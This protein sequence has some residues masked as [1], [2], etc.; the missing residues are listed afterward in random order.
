MS[1]M[2][3]ACQLQVS[4]RKVTEAVTHD[5]STL[6]QSFSSDRPVALRRGDPSS[7]GPV[8]RVTQRRIN[9]CNDN[10]RDCDIAPTHDKS[11]PNATGV[12][13]IW[14]NDRGANAS[15]EIPK[16]TSVTKVN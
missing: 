11:H 7:V 16:F 4:V 5:I 10:V 9:E 8:T 2:S 15:H 13:R 6:H 3:A 14:Q 1:A 12:P